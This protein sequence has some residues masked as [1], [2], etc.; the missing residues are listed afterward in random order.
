MEIDVNPNKLKSGYGE[1]VCLVLLKLTEAGLARRF[2]FNRPVIREEN[3]GM[4]DD[5]DDMGE[6]MEGEAD[7]ANEIHAQES[8]DDIDEDLDFGGGNIQADMAR[9][10]EAEQAQNAIIE[11][12][13]SKEKWQLEV[14]GIAHK[15][16]L[17]KVGDS[18]KEWRS[19]L[20]QTK[21][22][23]EQVRGS[24]PKVRS[25]LERLQDDASRALDKISRKEQI[26]SRNFQGMTGDYRAHTDQLRD[27]Q[28]SF[29]TVSKNVENLE[30]ELQ[31][32]NDRLGNVQRKID[33][34]GKQFSDNTPL[35]NIKKAISTVKNDIKAIDIRIGV[36]SNTLLQLKLKERTKVIEDGKALEILDN[37]YEIEM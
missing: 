33:D 27:I 32:I 1:G 5:A 6:D 37:E 29:T 15:L 10:L 35:T 24:L 20:E 4:D 31:E 7:L 34:T 13:I 25:K 18:G 12:N 11:S 9:E 30:T 14:E 2:Q 19:H 22:F 28:T 17:G 8:G 26:L 36:V 23:A 21:V 3:K 16:K